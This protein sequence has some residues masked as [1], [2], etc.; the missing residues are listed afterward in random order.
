M[1]QSQFAHV[2]SRV[3]VTRGSCSGCVQPLHPGPTGMNMRVV[4][5][6][7]RAHRN[8]PIES[9]SIPTTVIFCH[10]A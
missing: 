2:A 10:G 8:I 4:S 5:G 7:V 1:G 9:W 6:F 3:T